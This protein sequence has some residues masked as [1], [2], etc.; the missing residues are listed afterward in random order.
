MVM[1]PCEA[2]VNRPL[3][4]SVRC[5]LHKAFSD[6]GGERHLGSAAVIVI[7][8]DTGDVLGPFLVGIES[9][10][11]SRAARCRAKIRGCWAQVRRSHK[12]PGCLSGE[13][14][15]CRAIC[16]MATKGGKVNYEH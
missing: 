3:G 7:K 8:Q 9:G 10:Q 15:L 6:G 2:I 13:A 16:R 1:P 4:K 12:V 11:T 5:F 14:G